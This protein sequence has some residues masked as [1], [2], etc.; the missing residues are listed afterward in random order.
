[1]I[2]KLLSNNQYYFLPFIFFWI[3]GLLFIFF[4]SKG[5]AVL[6][7]NENRSAPANLFFL[8]ANMLAEWQFLLLLLAFMIWKSYGLT[9]VAMIS[10]V[11]GSVIVQFIKKIVFGWPRPAAFFEHEVSLNFLE[12][13]SIAY[14][15]SFP[16][17]HTTTAFLIFTALALFSNSKS[18]QVFY[19]FIALCVGVARIYLLQH[20]AMDVLAGAT[21]GIIVTTSVYLIVIK[22]N[23]FAFKKWSN[24]SLSRYVSKY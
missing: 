19:L 23:L 18:M 17:G 1:M 8:L 3:V 13:M 7:F 10:F 20:F 9:F 22:T 5:D 24:N 2:K 6:F 4:S 14:H 16:S 12:G 21:L 15:N 11:L